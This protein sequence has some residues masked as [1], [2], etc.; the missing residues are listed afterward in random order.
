MIDELGQI[1]ELSTGS[2]NIGQFGMGIG[3]GTAHSPHI[4]YHLAIF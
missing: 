4:M 1:R 3:R 2:N